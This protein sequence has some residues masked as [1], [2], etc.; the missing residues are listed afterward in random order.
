MN[1][2]YFFTKYIW[3]DAYLPMVA[4]QGNNANVRY[5]PT[6]LVYWRRHD[7]TSSI[8]APPRLR[9]NIFSVLGYRIKDILELLKA[10]FSLFDSEKKKNIRRFYK[11]IG[12]MKGMSKDTYEVASLLEKCSF[13][14]VC[15]AGKVCVRIY[16]KDYPDLSLELRMRLF[17]KP[18]F[19]VRNQSKGMLDS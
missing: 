14:D 11:R 4:F 9:K 15:K 19:S 16:L 5:V 12:E 7:S 17:F 18:F 13:F 8:A 3:L 6:P 10:I 1:D 2:T